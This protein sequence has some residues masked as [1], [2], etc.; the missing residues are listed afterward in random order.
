MGRKRKEFMVAY[1][2]GYQKVLCDGRGGGNGASC[3]QM[4]LFFH[5]DG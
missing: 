4:M 1:R 5:V 3:A 2:G